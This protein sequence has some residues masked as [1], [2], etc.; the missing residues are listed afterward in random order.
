MIERKKAPQD[1]AGRTKHFALRIV[2]LYAGLPLGIEAQEIGKQVV[3]SGTLL[4]AHYR[5]A[6]RARSNTEFAE[7]LEGGLLELEETAY[8]L[9]LLGESGSVEPQ[10]LTGLLAELNELTEIFET[11]IKT[12]KK[13]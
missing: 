13:R 1:L 3:R 9:E 11:C 2:R 4:G 7:K 6:S 12:A 10:R 8:W 5:Q